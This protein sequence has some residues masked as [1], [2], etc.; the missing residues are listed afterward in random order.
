MDWRGALRKRCAAQRRLCDRDR[1]GEA[2]ALQAR[3]RTHVNADEIEI[4]IEHRCAGECGA[5][6]HG[7]PELMLVRTRELPG[8]A[9]AQV[10]ALVPEPED[11]L[12]DGG[13]FLP[14]GERAAR[15]RRDGAAH[16]FEPDR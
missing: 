8:A 15:P 11:G 10:P 1:I 16:G 12:A 4:E 7:E 13:R 14:R 6:T 3:V 2:L 9:D 5:R